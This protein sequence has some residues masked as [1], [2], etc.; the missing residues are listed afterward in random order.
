MLWPLTL[1]NCLSRWTAG[2]LDASSAVRNMLKGA[3][4][5][6]ES[7]RDG[8]PS[9]LCRSVFLLVE[10]A[11]LLCAELLFSQNPLRSQLGELSQLLGDT[12][13]WKVRHET[14][15]RGARGKKSTPYLP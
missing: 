14:G 3:V 13:R 9:M 12:C 8:L 10:K 6:L 15:V 7:S 1:V 5:V 4:V 11:L 2:A